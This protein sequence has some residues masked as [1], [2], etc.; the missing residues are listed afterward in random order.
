VAYLI[1][2]LV[3][4]AWTGGH[5][6]DLT[7]AEIAN[8]IARML[9]LAPP[10]LAGAFQNMPH[11]S[12]NGSMWTIRYEFRCYLLVA[13]LGVLGLLRRRNVVL[14]IT[15]ALLGIHAF[16][17]FQG[18]RL[19]LGPL[20][21]LPGAN[22]LILDPGQLVRLGGVFGAGAC[23]WL[24]AD[25]IVYRGALAAACAAAAVLLL[26]SPAL[27]EVGLAIF[28]A[29]AMFWLALH[30]RAPLLERINSKDDI[31]YGLYLYAWPIGSLLAWYMPTISPVVL[32]IYT[33]VLSAIAG[34]ASWFLVEKHF[35]VRRTPSRAAAIAKPDQPAADQLRP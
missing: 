31:S 21:S 22:A 33:F 19:T 27:A 26:W 32:M 14:A 25:K 29:Y 35:M 4:G 9:M 34:A 1:C 15:L 2:F 10:E 6:A 23:F 24:F 17:T 7:L 18:A 20:A 3:V 30:C 5:L 28:G 11:P 16:V 8:A 12:L 13:L